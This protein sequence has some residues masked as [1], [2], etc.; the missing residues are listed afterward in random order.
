MCV[1]AVSRLEGGDMSGL[2]KIFLPEEG[3]D[4]DVRTESRLQM[5]WLTLFRGYTV[6]KARRIPF[7]DGLGRVRY[8]R[9]YIL[10]PDAP[11]E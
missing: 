2:F 7:L 6:Y 3:A 4:D 9:V 10:R 5:F 8:R 11:N 1:M